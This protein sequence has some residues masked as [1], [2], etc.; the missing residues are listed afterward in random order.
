V[1]VHEVACDYFY[2][3]G[4][5][6]ASYFLDVLDVIGIIGII[7]VFIGD[8]LIFVV[9]VDDVVVVDVVCI[10]VFPSRHSAARVAFLSVLAP[11]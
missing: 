5:F 2:F 1:P 10:V 6:R 3:D 9:V 11:G 7:I 8:D 4:Y